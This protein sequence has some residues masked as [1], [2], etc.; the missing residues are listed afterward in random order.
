MKKNAWFHLIVLI[1]ILVMHVGQKTFSFMGLNVFL[2]W[3]PMLLGEGLIR[4]KGHWRW[5]LAPFWLLFF[6]NIPYLLTDLIHLTSLGIYRPHGLFVATSSAWWSYFSLVLPIFVMV[7]VG[8]NQVFKIF[9]VMNMQK[10]RQWVSFS[11]LAVLSSIAIY[12]GRFE[13]IHSI[14]LLLR[15]VKVLE[16]LLGQWTMEK[17]Q[18]VCMFS[19]MQLLLWGLLA[20]LRKE[21]KE[22]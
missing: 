10:E 4:I 6:P 5:F 20:F 9:T 19:L 8:M 1:Y 14:A 16:L 13:R 22:E 21:G 18:F 2:A 7:L 12:L 15:P 11:V 17:F 3:L